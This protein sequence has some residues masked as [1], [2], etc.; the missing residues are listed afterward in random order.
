MN[1][2]SKQLVCINLRNGAEIWIE[3]R[4]GGTLN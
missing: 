2:I 1:E 3:K 4:T